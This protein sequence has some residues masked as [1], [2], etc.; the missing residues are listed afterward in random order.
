M[1][2][3]TNSTATRGRK[4]PTQKWHLLP[5]VKKL[6][7]DTEWEAFEGRMAAHC[8]KDLPSFPS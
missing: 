1:K 3:K 8:A 2:A 5:D 4:D 7:R 6:P